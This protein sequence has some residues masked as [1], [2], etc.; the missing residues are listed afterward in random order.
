MQHE[1]VSRD[2]IFAQGRWW[3][4]ARVRDMRL[5]SLCESLALITGHFGLTVG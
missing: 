5:P 1:G 3:T 2:C 4:E